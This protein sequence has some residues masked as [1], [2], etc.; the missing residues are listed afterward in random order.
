MTI[1]ICALCVIIQLPLA[2]DANNPD[3]WTNWLSI[4]FCFGIMIAAIVMKVMK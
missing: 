4:G 2:M 3:A 1:I